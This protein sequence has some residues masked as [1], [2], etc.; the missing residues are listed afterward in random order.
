MKMKPAS[1]PP[2]TGT[3]HRLIWILP[4][5]A[6]GMIGLYF[7]GVQL[8]PRVAASY[9]K[10]QL[11]DAPD[12]RVDLIMDQ[13]AALDEDGI[14]LLVAAMAS[15]REAVARAAKTRLLDQLEQGK[16]L[17]AE[18]CALRFL[19]LAEA[20]AGQVGEFGPAA[21]SDAADL[22][23]RILLSPA[24]KEG[25]ADRARLI[26]ACDEVFHAALADRGESPL[27][28]R[29][30]R[31]GEDDFERP[32]AIARM[33]AD[34]KAAVRFD[35]LPGG[36]L[37]IKEESSEEQN[38]SEIPS[39]EN[40][41]IPPSYF[42]APTN[43]RQ[44]DF[45]NRPANPMQVPESPPQSIP[46]KSS[47]GTEWRIKSTSLEESSR[48]ADQNP[49]E[50]RTLATLDLMRQLC[51]AENDR[52][53]LLEAELMRRGLSSVEID[54]GETNVR[55]RSG[56]AAQTRRGIARHARNRRLRVASAML[57]R[58]GRGSAAGGFL[59]FGDIEESALVAEG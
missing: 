43:S 49:L 27:R 34:K 38:S 46:K 35:P 48:A 7:T 47:P 5:L 4:L 57:Q 39:S 54:L 1:A 30:A 21:R 3:S 28:E 41:E 23:T 44:L 24:A 31:Q 33:D 40:G 11:A 8:Y 6:G 22:A 52:A 25:S 42:Q 20:L 50:L 26:A 2:F 12:D 10:S 51:D 45:S 29:S 15:E 14:P 37:P 56:R 18:K 53:K 9:W 17:A 16:S 13:I 36:G 55:C 59:A 32:L 19:R 58:R